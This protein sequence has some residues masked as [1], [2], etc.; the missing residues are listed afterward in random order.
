MLHT[1]AE[2]RCEIAAAQFKSVFTDDSTDPFKNTRLQGPS[3]PPIE[4]LNITDD[5]VKK[6]LEGV[7]TTKASGPDEIPCKLLKELAVE[8]APAIASFFRQSLETGKLPNPWHTAWITPCYKKGPRCDAENYRPISLTCVMC[9]FMGHL[10]CTHMR[11]H[12]DKYGILT[13]LNP[14]FPRSIPVKVNL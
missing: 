4:K 5:G 1:S 11:N 8:I 2:K 9:K 3:Y 6:L 7:D 12:F 13:K 14:G 10:I